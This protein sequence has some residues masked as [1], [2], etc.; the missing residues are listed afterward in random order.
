MAVKYREKWTRDETI[1]AL[2]LY[3][4]TPF[5]KIAKENKAI[6]ELA[7]LLG[8]TPSAVALKMSNLAHHDPEVKARNLTGMSNGSKLDKEV[9]LEFTDNW[10]ELSYQAQQIKS[11]ISK[12]EFV[13]L[14]KDN[15]VFDIEK[16]P[17]GE[18]KEYMIKTRIGQIFFREAVLSSYGNRCC[19]TG[20]KN[21][22]LLIASHIKPWKDSN[23][24]T[25]RTNPSN[26]LSLNALHDKIFD[27]GLMTIDK[28]YNIIYSKNLL[29]TTMDDDTKRWLL[30]YNGKKISLPDRFY[31]GK[32]FIEYHND[33]VFQG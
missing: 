13:D 27:S 9:F 19:I 31:P 12:T 21:S 16:I 11:K 17:P 25:E 24:E 23:S 26:G 7:K 1:L 33:I 14:W 15:A 30:Q 29:N 10:G 18:Y 28:N 2:D 4:R 6:Q 3:C 20:M 22:E 32:R 8:R 5:S